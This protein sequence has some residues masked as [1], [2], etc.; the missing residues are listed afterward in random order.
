M[1]ETQYS[2]SATKPWW[3]WGWRS[4]KTRENLLKFNVNRQL[5]VTEKDYYPGLKIIFYIIKENSNGDQWFILNIIESQY[6]QLI[7]A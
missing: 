7:K 4:T 6:Y 3:R 1:A 2:S 5:R